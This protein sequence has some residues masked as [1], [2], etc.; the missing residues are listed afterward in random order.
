MNVLQ[1]RK[2]FERM[3][4]D[5]RLGSLVEV[6]LP[7]WIPAETRLVTGVD[8]TEEA[9]SR[10][11]EIKSDIV[12]ISSLLKSK[13]SSDIKYNIINI[14][15]GYAFICRLHNGEHLANTLDSSEDMIK[16]CD[17]LGQGH[18]CGAIGDAIQSCI[19]KLQSG[20]LDIESTLEFNVSVIKDVVCL[21]AVTDTNNPLHN[22]LRALSDVYSMLKQASK[23]LSKQLKTVKK[24]ALRL[25]LTKR[26]SQLFHC[27]KK[28]EFL[29]SWS[30]SYG[31]V[32][33]GLVPELD[34]EYARMKAELEAVSQSKKQLEETWG[35]NRP[36]KKT[37]IQELGRTV[38]RKCLANSERPF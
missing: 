6:W 38:L 9:T 17:S 34:L 30:Q 36:K 21:V 25:L 28:I 31:M 19:A 15:Y 32:L 18:V 4:K 26:K 14:L 8:E 10:A 35:G 23:Q 5:G 11:S 2:E 16:L 3:V 37:L 12:P 13:P 33:N 1:E 29:L 22:V 24:E 20:T 27:I 7:W